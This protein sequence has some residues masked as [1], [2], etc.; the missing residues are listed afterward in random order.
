ML[1]PICDMTVEPAIAAGKFAYDGAAFYFCSLHCQK[2]F[3]TDLA[4]YLAAAK[5]RQE[6]QQAQPAVP[7]HHHDAESKIVI[8]GAIYTCPMDTKARRLSQGTMRNIRQNL[9]LRIF[10]QSARRANRRGDSLSVLRDSFEP[11][12][13]QRGDDL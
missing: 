3:Q 12:D 7:Q 4:K 9:Y 5:A 6:S 10:L 13:R 8:S 2:L 11:D 1:D